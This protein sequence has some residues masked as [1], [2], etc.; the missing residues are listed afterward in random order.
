MLNCLFGGYQGTFP[1][2]PVVIEIGFCH[3]LECHLRARDG[4]GLAAAE[5]R[6]AFAQ[7]LAGGSLIV[8]F[9]TLPVTLPAMPIANPSGSAALENLPVAAHLNHCPSCPGRRLR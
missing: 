1:V 7:Q 6:Q 5:I 3:L 8:R 4:G 2:H 9:G